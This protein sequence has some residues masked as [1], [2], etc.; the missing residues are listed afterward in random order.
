MEFYNKRAIQILELFEK[1]KKSMTSNQIAVSMGVSSRTVRNDIK[2]LNAY[3]KAFQA[4]IVS[5]S[6]EG[7]SLVVRDGELF[8]KMLLCMEEGGSEKKHPNIIPSNS[9]DR[10]GY[11]ISRL[12]TVSLNAGENIDF[13]DLEDELYIGTSTLKKDFRII[14]RILQQY[15]LRI[16][17]TK[18]SG[19]RITG[20]EAKVRY[21]IS[22]YV[23]NNEK[24]ISLEDN[25][26]YKKLFTKAE[27]ESIRKILQQAISNYSLRLSDIAFKNLLIHILIM[28]KRYKNAGMVVYQPDLIE[29][30]K[31]RREY[32]CAKEIANEIRMMA[33]VDIRDEVYYITQHLMSS[34]RF[35]EEN[36]GS[37]YHYKGTLDILVKIKEQTGI[38]LSDDEL[39][40]TGLDTHLSV[41]LQ[42]LKFHMNIR[43]E[44]L[45][46]VKTTY[47]LAFELAVLAGEVI[48]EDYS[49]QMK[50]SEI[51][52]MAIHFAVA[53]NRKGM[54]SKEMIKTAIIVC[55]GGRVT[56]ML[57]KEKIKQLFSSQIEIISV[58]SE[59]DLT[60]E[61]IDSVDFVFT[62][63]DLEG[64][65]CEKIK[66]VKMLLDDTDIREISQALKINHIKDDVKIRDIFRKDLF[67]TGL[68]LKTREEALKYLTDIL[69]DKKYITESVRQSIFKREEMATTELGCFVAI[70]HAL[71]NDMENAT[72]AV[73]ILN[74][75]IIW[76]REKVQVVLMLN[77]PKSKNEVWEV[78]F[79]RLYRE[80]IREQGVTWLIK[81]QDYKE[82]IDKLERV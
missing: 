28:L 65:A 52:Y 24:D 11:I 8:H 43:N 20:D 60:R 61:M 15:G 75:P 51:G 58:C 55:G 64:Y 73:A 36:D 56:A 14:E 16:S 10:V 50:E 63:V 35:L 18:K 57:M 19:V 5:K 45:D 48:E 38:D 33:Q 78:V 17:I 40:I 29:A 12:L 42:R 25:P 59:S 9:Q 67:F 21:C 72:V 6:G 41:A 13:Y 32:C 82:F 30:F 53:L 27:V 62:T 44:V 49:L 26:F 31:G 81:N 76:E 54:S 1:S 71:L 80:L 79:K 39:L 47:P 2:E 3:L 77:I 22:E 23:F 4:E 68:N 69:V 7:F 74:K 66:R 70:P 46:M 34:Q 37:G